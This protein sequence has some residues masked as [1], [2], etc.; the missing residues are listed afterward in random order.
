MSGA[1]PAPVRRRPR[2]LARWA[3]AA[4]LLAPAG[5]ALAQK[6]DVVV[7]INGDRNTGEFR[8]YNEGYLTLKTDN[9]GDL[10]IK[11]N[12]ILSIESEKTFEIELV[13]GSKIWGK[14]EPSEP[15]GK[16]IVVS[17]GFRRPLGFL[18]VVRIAPL[19]RNVWTGLNGSVDFG[20]TYTEAN[21]FVQ[22]NFNGEAT[23]RSRGF[24]LGTELSA[25]VSHQEGVTASER[26]YWQVDYGY[27]LPRLWYLGAVARFEHNKEL[28]LDLRALGGLGVGRHI[29]QTNQTLF[30]VLVGAAGSHETPIDGEG[31]YSVEAVVASRYTYF[32]Y[33]FPKLAF[34]V[35]VTVF[36]SL[37]DSGR[38]RLQADARVRRD[39]ISD[40]YVSV[41]IFDTFD[42]RPPTEGAAKNDW[43]PVVSVGYK[44]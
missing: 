35:D 2:L 31:S 41:S 36:P 4:L 39:I 32:M 14:L 40:F 10:R 3:I 7:M 42:S 28:G 22:L 5:A 20:F 37:T 44:F 16:L 29:V 8:S 27:F 13:D 12:K 38:V 24:Q 15:T 11:W 25:F 9:Q 18:D 33:D 23:Y 19:Y 26:A 6:T 1:R 17:G 34:G 43:G 30:D 21:S